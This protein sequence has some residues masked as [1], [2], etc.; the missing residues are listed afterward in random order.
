MLPAW[1]P[2]SRPATQEDSYVSELVYTEMTVEHGCDKHSRQGDLHPG[3]GSQCFSDEVIGEKAHLNRCRKTCRYYITGLHETH[4][5]PLSE[6]FPHISLF[7]LSK[8]ES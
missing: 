8:P 4:H 1:L 5:F 6:I 7:S 2:G 3:V